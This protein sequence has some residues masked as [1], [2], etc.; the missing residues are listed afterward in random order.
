MKFCSACAAPMP[1]SASWP[2]NCP[3]CGHTFFR[4]PLPVSVVLVPLEQ[5]GVLGV[6]RAIPPV[7]ELALPGGFVN[8]GETWQQAGA[9]E[10]EEETG[11][12]VEP[13]HLKLLD[14]QSVESGHLLVF[15]E[16]PPVS[17]FDP[18]FQ[19]DEV[20]ELVALSTPTRLAFETHS[21]ALRRFLERR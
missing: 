3:A 18:E 15:S 1:P 4:N 21:E 12:V 7:G 8:W 2:R 10:V 14:V 9:R 19:N 20:S 16:A 17:R 13:G 11:L 6:R 5:G